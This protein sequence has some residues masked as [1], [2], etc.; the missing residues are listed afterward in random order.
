MKF[1][2]IL[3]TYNRGSLL[4]R[5]IN[6]VV[7]Q[8][9]QNWTLYIIDDGS[10][11][12][13]ESMVAPYLVDSRIRYIRLET[14][15][16]KLNAL[17]VGLDC[18]HMDGAD[19]FTLMDDDDQLIDDC[20][21][22]VFA[23]IRQYSDCGLFI[24]SVLDLHGTPITRMKVTGP[25]DYCWNRMVTKNIVRDAHEFGA[26]CFL[27]S[28]RFHA[29]A[30]SAMLRIFFGEFSLKAGSVFCDRPTMIKEY[31]PDGITMTRRNETR[32]KRTEG[33]LMRIRHRLHVW[34]AVTRHHPGTFS[35]YCVY[36]NLIFHFMQYRILS[37]LLVL[38]RRKSHKPK[39]TSHRS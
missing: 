10:T 26:V 13:T 38:G 15:K 23:Q 4:P 1:A 11:D 14:N 27:G 25:R 32:R 6:S 16:G 8:T 18:I 36:G 21:D 2:I 5:A 31:L 20:L 28:Q 22:F 34:R 33:R 7:S 9:Y 30:R 29:P 12:D 19:W 39:N 35:I 17:N 3:A 37:W 24:F